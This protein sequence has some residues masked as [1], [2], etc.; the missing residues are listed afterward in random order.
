[1]GLWEAS[2]HG[3]DL[4]ALNSTN[5]SLSQSLTLKSKLVNEMYF[6]EFFF[7]MPNIVF[8]LLYYIYITY[9]YI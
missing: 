3:C 4:V 8:F 2:R 7:E 6:F 5:E 9:I 1:M